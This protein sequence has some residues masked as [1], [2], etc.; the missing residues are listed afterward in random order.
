[1]PDK[2]SLYLDDP[3]PLSVLLTRLELKAEVYV[4]GD[5]CGT[6]AV[7]TSGSKRIPFHIIG[8]GEAWL[9]FDGVQPQHLRA[10]DLIV[11]PRDARHIIADS[12]KCPLPAQVNAPVSSEGSGTSMICGF[13]EFRN[14]ALF[15][16]LEALPE[17][18]LLSSR[19][20][21]A[22]RTDQLI[23]LM[24]AELTEAKPGHYAAVDQIAFLIFVEVIRREMALGRVESGLL[25][26]LFDA[27]VGRALSAMHSS[28]ERSW[29][30]ATL[31]EEAAMSRASFADRFSQMVGVTPMKYLT[32]WRMT[33]AR[34]LL[35]T[36]AL[37]IAQI[38]QRS[39]YDS[40]AAFRKA[41][42]NTLG[43]TPGKVRKQ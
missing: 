40:E 8:S 13:F 35:Q 19:E 1:M 7:D 28:P 14:P 38:A 16:F 25:Q 37:S 42:R 6:W 22:G 17:L 41:F 11:F 33:E 43:V 23:D 31:A 3:D 9:H 32:S 34:R 27:K 4:N 12:Q 24:C 21:G 26:A 18:V 30:L 39:G 2:P 20:H 36:T 29:T 10:R 5:F 15:P